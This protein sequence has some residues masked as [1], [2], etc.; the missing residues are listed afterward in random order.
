MNTTQK[1]KLSETMSVLLIISV[2]LI[3]ANVLLGVVLVNQSNGA[4]KAQI[5]AR[6]LD[7]T[8]TAADMIDGDEFEK[9]TEEDVRKSEN[10]WNIFYT[11]KSFQDNIDLEFI[12][13]IR[14]KTDNEF[15]FVIDS[16]DDND[17]DYG[18]LATV[19]PALLKAAAGTSA[20]D[21]LPYS[22]DWGKFY[23]AYTPI[24][25]S[26]GEVAGLVVVDFSATWYEEQ[27]RKNVYAV[28]IAVIWSIL[29]GIVIIAVYSVKIKLREELDKNNIQAGKMI[30]ALASD[31]RSVY[32]V[33]L[34]TDEGVCYNEHSK[35]EDGLK[36]GE[37]FKYSDTFIEYANKYV[38]DEFRE[39]FIN[40]IEPDTIRKNL[41][42]EAIIA[43]RYLVKR[44]GQE[45]YEMLRMA[46]VRRPED[47]D[48][49]IVHAV[50]IG[51]TDVDSETRQTLEQRKA[52]IDALNIAE[53]ANNAKTVFLSNMSH[54]IRTPMNAIIGLDKLALDEKDIPKAVREYLVKIGDSAEHLLSII[55]DIL[56]MSRIESGK[57]NIRNEE[58]SIKKLMSQ[59]CT[60]VGSQCRDKDISYACSIDG[61]IDECYLGDPTRLREII[62]NVLSNSVKYTNP[63]GKIEFIVKRTAVYENKA[64]LMFTMRD[65]GIG[66]DKDFLPKIFDSFT[67]E[68]ISAINKYGSTGLGMAITKNLVDM[69]NGKIAIDSK[70]GEG[71]VV[72]VVLTFEIPQRSNE[73]KEKSENPEKPVSQEPAE[74]EL[75]GRRIL[76]AEDMDI[77]AQILMKILTRKGMEADRAANGEEALNMFK[78]SE[79]WHYDAILM[80]MRMPVM[81]GLEAT[82]AIRA[83]DREDA[84]KIPIIA[85]TANAFDEDVERSLQAGLDAHLSKPL[86]PEVIFSTLK[87]LIAERTTR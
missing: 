82:I 81:T 13:A 19:T 44:G 80:D 10:Y 51:F 4:L 70:K 55:N 38:T 65:N 25:N 73:V 72:Y 8:K 30:N 64:T 34:D 23:S 18:H 42:N 61:E 53:E 7:I 39:G 33:D 45:S 36:E 43:F 16:S 28:I 84:G 11:L 35:L 26:A 52:L 86:Q 48:D 22:D 17:S 59:I 66:M 3:A 87:R 54:E 31:Y 78:E 62:I 46:G 14:Q 69:M 67:K 76:I 20:V 9:I 21:E 15:I 60:L 77:N 74:I 85:L 57:M 83:L 50:G 47:R 2:F 68:D 1:K 49:H 75:D 24:F 41:E 79:T 71:T 29:V 40:F 58:F 6:M 12:Y 27:L 32:Y 5:D 56:D 37:Q 63:G